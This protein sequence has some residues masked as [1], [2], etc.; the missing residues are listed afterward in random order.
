MRAVVLDI[1]LL[2][3]DGDLARHVVDLDA[4]GRGEFQQMRLGLLGEVEQRLGAVQPISASSSSAQA[5]WPV[6]S[7][8]PLRPEA[9]SPKR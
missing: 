2:V 1:A 8:P 7:W 5:R 6:P 3:R 9:P 4:V